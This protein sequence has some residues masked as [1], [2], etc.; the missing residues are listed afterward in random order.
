MTKTIETIIL[1]STPEEYRKHF[2]DMR[3]VPSCISGSAAPG[4]TVRIVR[5]RGP[6]IGV[7]DAIWG[8]VPQWRDWAGA[9]AYF[10]PSTT[11]ARQWEYS[12]AL[13]NWRCI[14]PARSFVHTR[15]VDGVS[16]HYELSRRGGGLMLLAGIY[17]PGPRQAV[18]H[19]QTV[20]L[21]TTAPNR[22][23]APHGLHVPL[24][25]NRK[26][27]MPWLRCHTNIDLIRGFIRPPADDCLVLTI[28]IEQS[29]PAEMQV[30]G[31]LELV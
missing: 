9:P 22:A 29:T 5:M 28:R 27:V 12:V 2:P 4:D 13:R 24:L 14:V 25:L 8:F 10:A 7:G 11:V 21:V 20:A 3:A 30:Q 18:N 23:L 26:Q 1:T 15:Q 31:D 19:A 6:D 16:M 17:E